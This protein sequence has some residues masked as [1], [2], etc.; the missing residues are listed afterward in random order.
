M[1]SLLFRST[2][3][4]FLRRIPRPAARRSELI[5][6]ST[7]TFGVYYTVATTF[8][9]LLLYTRTLILCDSLFFAR[10]I[11]VY[12]Y[13]VVQVMIKII[14]GF[15]SLPHAF[16]AHPDQKVHP[17]VESDLYRIIRKSFG[18]RFTPRRSDREP[19]TYVVSF[20]ESLGGHGF[21]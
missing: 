21:H 16:T 5:F 11:P 17:R 10:P 6:I 4:Y 2:C 9:N 7:K 20:L 3:R 18:F 15:I 1:Q 19:C 14:L 13:C 12:D 8:Y